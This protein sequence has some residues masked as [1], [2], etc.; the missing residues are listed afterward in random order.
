LFFK[1]GARRI[2][3]IGAL[4]SGSALKLKVFEFFASASG[5]LSSTHYCRSG[6]NLK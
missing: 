4:L 2:S 6:K 1:A 3:K 5:L